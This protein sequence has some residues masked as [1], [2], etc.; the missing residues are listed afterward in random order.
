LFPTPSNGGWRYFTTTSLRDA[1]VMAKKKKC[2]RPAG[3]GTSNCAPWSANAKAHVPAHVKVQ[4]V[5]TPPGR[6]EV[7]GPVVGGFMA[8]WRALRSA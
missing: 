6:Y 7:K 1:F 8:E 5:P 4:R 2:G 3:M